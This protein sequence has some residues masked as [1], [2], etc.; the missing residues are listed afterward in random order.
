MFYR[1]LNFTS[2]TRVPPSTQQRPLSPV[3]PRTGVLSEW[4]G[5]CFECVVSRA[6]SLLRGVCAVRYAALLSLSLLSLCRLLI[7]APIGARIRRLAL[8]SLRVLRCACV[9]ACFLHAHLSSRSHWYLLSSLASLSLSLSSLLT[10]V[11]SSYDTFTVRRS[12]FVP[13]SLCRCRHSLRLSFFVSSFVPL[14]L[15]SVQL[16]HYLINQSL[17]TT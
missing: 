5:W 14:S 8:S 17:N 13:V 12:S 9:V 15:N 2:L 4:A 1:Q 10:I 11:L 6:C 16:L 7:L 3:A